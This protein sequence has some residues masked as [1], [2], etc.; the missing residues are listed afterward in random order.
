M[1][2]NDEVVEVPNDLMSLLFANL[3]FR[4]LPPTDKSLSSLLV[5]RIIFKCLPNEI[6]PSVV[7]CLAL[8]V[9]VLIQSIRYT[10]FLL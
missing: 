9:L 1:S 6:F 3:S 8:H 5:L 2:M 7:L 4:E 10:L